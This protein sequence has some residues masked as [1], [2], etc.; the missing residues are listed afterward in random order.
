MRRF[1]LLLF[2]LL[3][4]LS[5]CAQRI[6]YIKGGSINE[7]GCSY[8]V[9]IN[10]PQ[11]KAYTTEIVHKA[12]KNSKYLFQSENPSISSDGRTT[13]LTATLDV[14]MPPF[15]DPSMKD[16]RMRIFRAD[17]PIR[18]YANCHI[19]LLD[20]GSSLLI[21]IEDMN[22]F[23]FEMDLDTPQHFPELANKWSSH[24]VS[25]SLSPGEEFYR[26][27]YAIRGPGIWDKGGYLQTMNRSFSDHLNESKS[28]CKAL[29]DSNKG[30]WYSLEEYKAEIESTTKSIRNK[31]K[32]IKEL[33]RLIKDKR[34]RYITVR[35][36]ERQIA[37]MLDMDILRLAKELG[38]QIEV[39]QQDGK[40]KWILTSGKLIPA[41]PQLAQQF[42]ELGLI[43]Y[44]Q[45]L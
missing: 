30:N 25:V 44:T 41:D 31:K 18:L 27:L 24:H 20:R 42:R 43:D 3:I 19:E 21:L 29:I 40:D 10:A 45:V 12:L 9:K 38:G 28:L 11:G 4:C 6:N 13:Q 22:S 2:G 39:I 17:P 14:F 8:A 7:G 33:D 23:F 37:G 32:L 16:L 15:M 26:K 35:R 1:S 5:L 36:W 34:M